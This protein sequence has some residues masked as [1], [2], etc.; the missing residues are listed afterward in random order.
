MVFV[1]RDEELSILDSE[2]R[3]LAERAS[4][5]VIYGRRR[6]G[7]TELI[8]EFGRKQNHLYFLATLQSKEEVIRNFSLKAAEFF[9]DKATLAQPHTTWEGF[10]EYLVKEIKT[11]K[12][13]IVLAFD[14]FTYLIQQDH[15]TPSIFQYQWDEKLKNLPVMLILCGSYVGMMEK[16]VISYKSPLYGRSS[17]QLFVLELDFS[18]LREFMPSY[19]KEQLVE[20]YAILGAVPFYL[21]Q[22]D[23]KKTPLE[24]VKNVFLDKS[25]SLYNDGLLLLREEVKE[26]R[27]YLSILKAISFGKTTPKEIADNAHLDQLLVGKYLD[28]LRGMKLVSRFVPVTE[29]NPEKS[30]KGIYKITDN[31]YDFW[32]KFVYPYS[33]YIEEGRQ[34]ELMKNIIA[35]N[36][37]TYVGRAFEALARKKLI[38]LNRK[39]KLPFSFEHVGA[40]W[41]GETEIDIVAPNPKTKEILFVEVKWSNLKEKEVSGILTS[42]KE[43]AALVNW[44]NENRKEYYAVIA[45]KLQKKEKYDA[46][47]IDLDDF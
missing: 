14:E 1:D 28:V 32:L 43:K 9:N 5:I 22:F 30:K 19:S 38:E 45:K 47:L 42:L 26:P 31:Y 21:L 4:L 39:G 18:Y 35:P 3:Q 11:R 23:P 10:F 12:T 17:R 16:E 13:P 29:K 6:V 24:N 7:K 27:N 34:N 40:W 37:G 46:L 33:D 15:A 44:N 2:F 36:F 41:S 25:R 20:L 8:K